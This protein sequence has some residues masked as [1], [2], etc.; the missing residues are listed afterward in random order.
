MQKKI[1]ML[2]FR[3]KYFKEFSKMK[4]L[5]LSL[6]SIVALSTLSFAGG[7][8]VEPPVVETPPVVVEATSDLKF[9]ANMT[10]ASKYVWRGQQ[11]IINNGPAIQG[12]VDVEYKGF[13]LGT[14]ASNVDFGGADNIEL[15]VY[16]G[17]AGEVA[18]I[19]FDIGM[20]AYFFP[21]TTTD[22][23]LTTKEVY[24]G[25]S[26]AFGDFEIGG[27]YY[28]SISDVAAVDGL[29]TIEGTASYKLP[30]DVT[31]SGTIGT[32]DSLFSEDDFYYSVGLSKDF[33]NF[34]VAVAYTGYEDDDANA[35]VDLS[36]DHIVASISASF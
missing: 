22:F 30:Y 12:G 31:V 36:Q 34:T 13:Y 20:I 4:K 27:K 3:Y 6:A 19:G 24:F 16:G 14:W 35:L 18:G 9:S 5:T 1:F 15:D 8:I 2:Q 10:L 21:N 23:G 25:L 33:G 11:Q 26:K 32:G 28:Y 29:Y 7:E 17:Y